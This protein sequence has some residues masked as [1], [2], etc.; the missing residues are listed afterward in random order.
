MEE[1]E[2]V[3]LSEA[4]VQVLRKILGKRLYYFYTENIKVEA[5]GKEVFY[6]AYEYSLGLTS[7]KS[8]AGFI[9]INADYKLTSKS[10]TTYYEFEIG[11]SRMPL[12]KE[13]LVQS[14]Q[15]S[16]IKVFAAPVLM[17]EIYQDWNQEFDEII[18]Y[19]AALVVYT[20]SAKYMLKAR[21]ELVGGIDI[22]TD[23]KAID[24][25]LVDL[26]LR[27]SIV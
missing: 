24:T 3:K 22:L 17:I 10:S 16:E 14:G 7:N 13:R 21:E 26:K 27:Q 12:R 6:W 15:Y 9:N 5:S 1:K 25:L 20:E 4:D 23:E 11:E 19:D 8:D 2:V 18:W